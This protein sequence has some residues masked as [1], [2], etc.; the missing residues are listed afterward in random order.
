MTLEFKDVTFTIPFRYDSEERLR[1]IRTIISYL[2]K[3]FETNIIVC[4][5][6][7]ERKFTDSGKFEYIHI[8][9]DN[10]YMHRTKCLNI[11]AKMAKTPFIVNYDTDVLLPIRQYIESVFALR[12]DKFDMIYPYSGKFINYIPP[13]LDTIIN[14]I[15]L[16]GITEESGHVIHPSSVGGAVFWNK[17]KFI[18]G[19]ME[20]ENFISW[21]YEDNERLVRFTRL[22]LR[23]HRVSGS[24]Y[25][26][27]HP[28]SINSANTSSDAYKRNEQEFHKINGMDATAIRNY[29][30]TWQWLQ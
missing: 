11:M 20:N 23:V 30:K 18:S 2:N 9:T 4:E 25:H 28:S 10:Q 14:N 12:E 16:D 26:L 7:N 1:N 24:A 5:E 22:G 27:N 19:G 13:Q 15:S 6:S 8:Q 3:Y 29:M 21:G 17:S